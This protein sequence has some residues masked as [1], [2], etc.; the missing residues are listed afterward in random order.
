MLQYF[1]YYIHI[2]VGTRYLGAGPCTT[3]DWISLTYQVNNREIELKLRFTVMLSWKFLVIVGVVQ[4]SSPHHR[5]SMH[6]ESHSIHMHTPSVSW[7]NQESTAGGRAL[8]GSW[9]RSHSKTAILTS[10][11]TKQTKSSFGEEPLCQWW[12]CKSTCK[13]VRHLHIDLAELGVVALILVY[14][15]YELVHFIHSQIQSV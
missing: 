4:T 14:W 6:M 3:T 5:L 12:I 8:A 9:F 10:S 7:C 11:D 15:N 1:I 2:S 13:T